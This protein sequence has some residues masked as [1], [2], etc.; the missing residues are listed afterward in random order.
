MVNE[1][2]NK[3]LMDKISELLQE[4][5]TLPLGSEEQTAVY[6]NIAKLYSLAFEDEKMNRDNWQK[7]NDREYE[8]KSQ[9]KKFI[10]EAIGVGITGFSVGATIVSVFKGFKFEETGSISSQTQRN[11][12]SKMFRFLQ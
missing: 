6:N 4:A 2:L 1:Q 8:K 10:L 11:L 9:K 12:F 3:Q 7:V 5:D